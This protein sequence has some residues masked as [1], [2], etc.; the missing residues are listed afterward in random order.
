MRRSM[1]PI[2]FHSQTYAHRTIMICLTYPT[3]FFQVLCHI[4]AFSVCRTLGTSS[5]CYNEKFCLGNVSWKKRKQDKSTK[6]IYKKTIS[7]VVAVV[8]VSLRKLRS[9]PPTRTR[10]SA[11]VASLYAHFFPFYMV[12]MQNK[13]KVI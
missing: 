10:V 9:E 11:I 8:Q 2:L 3:R 6:Y 7:T 13:Y 5:T 1:G 4:V 12:Q